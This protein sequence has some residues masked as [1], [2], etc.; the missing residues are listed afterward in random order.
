MTPTT[1]EQR[2]RELTVLDALLLPYRE[3]DW[4]RLLLIAWLREVGRQELSRRTQISAERLD[5]LLRGGCE[6]R[7][8]EYARIREVLGLDKLSFTARRLRKNRRSA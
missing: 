1:Q 7:G 2:Q 6:P 4:L 5:R 3:C 8:N